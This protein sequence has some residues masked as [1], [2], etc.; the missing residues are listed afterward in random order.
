[1]YLKFLLT[2]LLFS[3]ANSIRNTYNHLIIKPKIDF[4]KKNNIFKKIISINN[5]FYMQY[6][7]FIENF[8]NNSTYNIDYYIEQRETLFK[9]NTL[10]F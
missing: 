5:F 10:I 9:I 6:N 3:Y 4:S 1:M 7:Y 8:L 2:I